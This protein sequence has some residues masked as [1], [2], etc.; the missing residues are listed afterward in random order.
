MSCS[1]SRCYCLPLYLDE[2]M[3]PSCNPRTQWSDGLDSSAKVTLSTSGDS[4][5]A[6]RATIAVH[7]S[8]DVC[9]VTF[10]ADRQ[11]LRGNEG[12]LLHRY[13]VSGLHS[14]THEASVG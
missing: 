3:Y 6:P 13:T 14:P 11:S 5:V 10:E 7:N 8:E 4:E 1:H 9:I 12:L 2:V